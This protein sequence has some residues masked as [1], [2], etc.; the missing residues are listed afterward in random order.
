MTAPPGRSVRPHTLF[1]ALAYFAAVFAVG[2]VLGVA[3]EFVV[4][5]RMGS[6][7]AIMVEAP[8]MLLAC[9]VFARWAVGR[10]SVVALGDRAR[11][12]GLAFALLMVAELVGSMVLR[13]LTPLGWLS[14]YATPPGFLS[15]SLFLA[16]AA[17]PLIVRR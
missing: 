12:G 16:F 8:A 14:H 9:W 7:A 4:R 17:M 5:P 13:G 2:F 3:R 15:L 10:F 11:M 6:F 1:A